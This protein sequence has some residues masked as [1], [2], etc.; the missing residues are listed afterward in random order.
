MDNCFIAKIVS[1][2]I[3]YLE[4]VCRNSHLITTVSMCQVCTTQSPV[5]NQSQ[6]ASVTFTLSGF[7]STDFVQYS[8][9][10]SVI[11]YQLEEG[12]IWKECKLLHLPLFCSFLTG[13]AFFCCFRASLQFKIESTEMTVIVGE[14]LAL[15]C[16]FSEPV[17]EEYVIW[18]GGV[19]Y[20]G[21]PWAPCYC[22]LQGW[23]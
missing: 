20:W 9:L 12:I 11:D 23:R 13:V 5:H 8:L 3:A 21:L 4:Q 7:S 17:E 6:T 10:L 2:I 1:Y 16:N 19:R 15:M 22:M 14:T 18:K